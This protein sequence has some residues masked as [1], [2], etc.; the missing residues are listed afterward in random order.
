[1]SEKIG[2]KIPKFK[3]FSLWSHQTSKQFRLRRKAKLETN[4]SQMKYF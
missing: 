1:M 4:Q 2:E 3:N